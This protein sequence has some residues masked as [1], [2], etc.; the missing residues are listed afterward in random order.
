MR[1]E[2]TQLCCV[3]LPL[4]LGVQPTAILSPLCRDGTGADSPLPSSA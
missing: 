2:G 4:L 1:V 3:F